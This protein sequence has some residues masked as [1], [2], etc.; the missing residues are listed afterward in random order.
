MLKAFADLQATS[1]LSLDLDLVAVS[2]SFARGNEN[3]LHQPDGTYYLGPGT[4]PGYGVRE[5]RRALSADAAAAA[6]RADQQPV[7]P[8][9]QQR[10]AARADRLHQHGQLHRPAAAAI[11]GEFPW[12]NA[13]FYAPGSPTTAWIGLRFRI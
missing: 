2:S 8:P 6:R 10:R 9:L 4:S 7:R 12:C 5:P 13:T 1:R 3:N 11:G